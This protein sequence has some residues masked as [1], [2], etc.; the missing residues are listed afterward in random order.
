M[1]S[2]NDPLSPARVTLGEPRGLLQRL[3]FRFANRMFGRT[4][5]SMRLMTGLPRLFRGMMWMEAALRATRGLDPRTHVLVDVAAARVIGCRYCLDIGGWVAMQAGIDATTLRNLDA[6]ERSPE[7]TE[8]ERAAIA[9]AEAMSA[10]P[11]TVDDALFARLRRSYTE[12]QILELAAIAGWE[13]YRARINHAMGLA[14]NGFLDTDV[15]P[16]PKTMPQATDETHDR[17]A[18]P[19]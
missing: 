8:A 7:F 13:Q 17:R 16:M 19:A 5:R 14:P 9:F 18:V 4:P 2:S 15:C 3:V 11:P 6:F 10:T 12:S 1:T